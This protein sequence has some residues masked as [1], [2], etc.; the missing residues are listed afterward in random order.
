WAPLTD[1][2]TDASGNP[3]F[4]DVGGMAI[5]PLNAKVLYV[6]TGVADGAL[7]SQ[8]GS[9][10]LKTV[11]GGKTW[12]VAGNSATVLAGARI[13]KMIV[14]NDDPNTAY[15]AVASGGSSGPGVYKTTDG[16]L[17]WTNVM[18]PT[19]M[20]DSNGNTLAAGSAL[21][22]VTDLVIDPFNPNRLLAGLGNVGLVSSSAISGVW[23]STNKGSSWAQVR[24][25]DG[26]VPNS[27][28]PT[29]GVN[30][31][32]TITINATGGT[33]TIT[34]NGQTTGALAFNASQGTVQTALQGLSTIG[35]GNVS[36]SLS[37]T[38][39]TVTFVGSLAATNV[40]QMTTDPSGLNG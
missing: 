36:V 3:V 8:P 35:T 33:F 16:G 29:S 13:S 19:A 34:F 10:I 1:H 32:Q 37:G 24:G 26:N 30:E 28:I 9:G 11:N 14:D 20:V 6:G 21:A 22:S 31:V 12:T 27:T 4:V 5:S 23:L 38:V 25:G 7:D 40:N 39:Y 17:T 2:V 15:A 18:V